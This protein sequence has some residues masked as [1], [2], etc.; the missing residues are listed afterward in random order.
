[1]RSSSP[2]SVL[3]HPSPPPP[4]EGQ[5]VTLQVQLDIHV[6]LLPPPPPEPSTW[7]RKL[8]TLVLKAA[9]YLVARW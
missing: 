4:R 2:I 7:W 3:Y 1:M 6:S 9:P 5:D 8:V